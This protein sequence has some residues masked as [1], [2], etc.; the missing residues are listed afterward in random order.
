MEKMYFTFGSW[1]KFPHHNTYMVVVGVDKN[2]CIEGFRR[3]YPDI[4]ENTVNCSSFYLE[5]RWLEHGCKLYEGIQP[6]ETIITELAKGEIAH[7]LLVDAVTVI[8]R[9][10]GYWYNKEK[11]KGFVCERIGTTEEE[12]RQIG[13][14][15]EEV[16]A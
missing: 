9:N 8:G 15:L 10:S 5:D 11:R 2:D 14:D 16:L 4:Y 1:E 6:A 13:V 3:V 12:L 7:K